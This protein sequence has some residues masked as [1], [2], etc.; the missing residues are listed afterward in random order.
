MQGNPPTAIVA[1]RG[2]PR[3]GHQCHNPS[4]H[5][6]ALPWRRGP[7]LWTPTSQSAFEFGPDYVSAQRPLARLTSA[8]QPIQKTPPTTRRQG[9]RIEVNALA[10]F[11]TFAF[12]Q[13][14]PIDRINTF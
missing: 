1:R 4:A 7:C 9:Q 6:D 3:L 11:E 12:L 13:N 8:V 10:Y 14:S 5:L 2:I